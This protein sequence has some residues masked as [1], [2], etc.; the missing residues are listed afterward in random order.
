MKKFYSGIDINFSSRNKA[1]IFIEKE[2]GKLDL[3]SSGIT[4]YCSV[5]YC[6]WNGKR[7]FLISTK[8]TKLFLTGVEYGLKQTHLFCIRISCR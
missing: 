8:E 4:G 6:V 2:R 3:G 7:L 5:E 1:G